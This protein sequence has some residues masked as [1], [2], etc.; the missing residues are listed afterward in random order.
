M[1][2]S[3]IEGERSL[4][5]K[6][7]S[8]F[9]ICATFAALSRYMVYNALLQYYHTGNVSEANFFHQYMVVLHILL[10]PLYTGITYLFFYK[11]KYNLA[12]IGILLLY[13]VSFFFLL[14]SAIALLKFIWPHLDTAYIELPIL[15]VYNI[16]TFVNFFHDLPRWRVVLKGL[17]VLLLLFVCTQIAE[18]Y[19]VRSIS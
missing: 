11:A 9:F 18:D 2:R 7:F 12:E 17:L 19:V 1:Q 8:M 5:Q 14:A 13:T 6:P 4:H 16:I 15:A 10:L 3:Y